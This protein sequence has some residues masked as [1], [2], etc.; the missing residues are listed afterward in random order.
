MIERAIKRTS[1]VS[2]DVFDTLI[3]RSVAKPSDLFRLMEAQGAPVPPGFTRQRL[4]AERAAASRWKR[5]VSLSEIYDELKNVYGG[6][7][8]ELMRLEVRT[9]LDGCRPNRKYV[10]LLNMCVETGKRVVLIS[11]MYLSGEIVG[12]ML[13]RCGV[14]GYEKLFI[15]CE[16]GKSKSEGTLFDAVLSELN[17]S[18]RELLHVGD[19]RRGDMAVPLSKG[20]RVLPVPCRR[21]GSGRTDHDL[22]RRTL[23][24]CIADVAPELNE[25][26]RLGCRT[27]GPLLAGFGQWLLEKLRSD[28]IY[29]VYFMSR[30]GYMIKQAFDIFAP[31]DIHTH[32][33]YCSRRS[34]TVPLIW[35]HPAFDDLIGA[36]TV[37][38]GNKVLRRFLMS[39]GLDPDA[40]ADTAA[41]YG[42]GLDDTYYTLGDFV[43]SEAVRSFY[44]QIQP[45]VEA[46]SRQEY[47]AL[48][49]YIQSCDF[50]NHIAVV[51]IG[52]HGTMQNALEQVIREM[53]LDVCVKGYYLGVSIDH[54]PLVTKGII[55]AEGYLY[56]PGKN[57]E[58]FETMGM[59]TAIFESIFLAQH[60]SV[61]RFVLNDGRAEPELCPYEYAPEQ[62]LKLDETAVIRA[63]QQGA[64]A[65]VRHMYEVLSHRP[66][67]IAPEIAAEDLI[68]MGT[69]PSLWEARLWGDFRVYDQV[70]ADMARPWSW[71][72]YICHPKQLRTDFMQSIW[73]IGFMRRVF[74]LPL[75]YRYFY[76]QLKKYYYRR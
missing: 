6:L 12:A 72:R 37:T 66:L 65:L 9:E 73:K 29:D 60:G 41:K 44:K 68:R 11:D 70:I 36:V 30:D 27:F 8:Q 48:F 46:L 75:P 57:E 35:K 5:P 21:K 34:Y 51:D 23:D 53:G 2:F 63:Y 25:Y 40:Y 50:E 4:A 18:P 62:G 33:L 13:D 76:T 71:T 7:C 22:A 39:L 59:F 10:S 52:Y 61:R 55:K 3:H 20:I 49:R 1:V 43:H 32:Y 19:N 15:S 16:I 38:E 56:G 69:E 54:A 45:E 17:V 47:E 31:E 58:T 28:G 42:L 74:V 24:T 14:H 64:L 26:G 67:P